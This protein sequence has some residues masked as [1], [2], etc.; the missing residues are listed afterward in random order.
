MFMEYHSS[1]PVNCYP[2]INIL[3]DLSPCLQLNF[4]FQLKEKQFSGPVQGSLNK[5][6]VYILLGRSV[7]SVLLHYRCSCVVSKDVRDSGEF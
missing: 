1:G 5:E 2:S 3:P 6:I 7:D 4:F